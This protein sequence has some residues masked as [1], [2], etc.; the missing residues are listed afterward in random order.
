MDTKKPWFS[1]T[2][3]ANLVMAVLAITV[4]GAHEWAVANP[5]MMAMGFA[6]VNAIL[7][8]ATKDKLQ[9]RD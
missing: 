9:L 2:L 4:P 7:R 6:A 5:E 8:L 1:K 3:W